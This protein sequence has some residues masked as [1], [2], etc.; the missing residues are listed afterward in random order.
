[1]GRLAGLDVTLV[2]PM[3]RDV[4]SV[5]VGLAGRGVSWSNKLS[6]MEEELVVL[7]MPYCTLSGRRRGLGGIGGP[8]L[9]EELLG[10]AG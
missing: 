10:E 1:M 3:L 4:L 2:F 9:E 7:L 8:A 6:L 5:G